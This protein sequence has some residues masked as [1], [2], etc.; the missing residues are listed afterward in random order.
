[1]QRI[2]PPKTPKSSSL[3][4]RAAIFEQ[5][6]QKSTPVTVDFGRSNRASLRGEKNKS[7]TDSKFAR[8][9]LEREKG[10]RMEKTGGKAVDKSNSIIGKLKYMFLLFVC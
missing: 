5:Q 2:E 9:S 3:K 8:N 6:N 1:M 4:V 7:E 10:D